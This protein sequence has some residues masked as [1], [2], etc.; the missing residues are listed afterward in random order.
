MSKKVFLRAAVFA[1]ALVFPV[2]TFA[3][4]P[5][6][7]PSL[8]PQGILPPMM[9]DM[10]TVLGVVL[11]VLLLIGVAYLWA[12]NQQMK[13]K[14][15]KVS[16]LPNEVAHLSK[17]VAALEARLAPAP[18]PE[19]KEE[20]AEEKPAEKPQE[21]VP[22]WQP[23]VDDYNHLARS[24]DI[25]E[26]EKA[27]ENFVKIQ[28]ITMLMCLDHAA[29]LDGKPAPKFVPVTNV[30]A[31]VYWASPLPGVADRYAIV[32]NPLIVYDEK[33]HEEGGMK[34]TFASNYESGTCKHMDVKLPALF[35]NASGNWVIDQPGMIHL[36]P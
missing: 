28:K 31:S 13:S 20:P 9:G 5:P 8:A 17:N 6:A 10:L 36:E 29:Q 22:S 27:C 16:K 21:N 19:P 25:P 11:N 33:M 2:A 23:F 34:E 4:E 14:L 35:H 26:A 15:S 18:A 30:S 1:A 24:M 3:A 12:S 7:E 32:P